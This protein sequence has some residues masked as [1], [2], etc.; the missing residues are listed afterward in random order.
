MTENERD[1]V[2]INLRRAN[3]DE[4]MQRLGELGV[5]AREFDLAGKDEAVERIHERAREIIKELSRRRDLRLRRDMEDA[6][7]GE[8]LS[9]SE[10]DEVEDERADPYRG[11]GR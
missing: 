10:Y 1:E 9:A 3:V 2:D 8:F 7:R 6:D 4:L 5:V 11:L